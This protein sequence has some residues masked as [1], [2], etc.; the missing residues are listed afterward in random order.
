MRTGIDR[1]SGR[2]GWA[3]ACGLVLLST[4][5]GAAAA[6]K[7]LDP[8]TRFFTP[9]ADQAGLAQAISLALQGREREA[10]Q[11]AAMEL[12]P[13]GVW[14]NGGTTAAVAKQVDQTLLAARLTG[15]VPLLVLYNIPGRD[16]GGYSA[17]GA[18]TTADYQAWIDTIAAHIGHAQV[19]VALEPDALAN[20]PSDCGYDSDGSLT[21]ARYAQLGYALA[22][23]ESLPHAS[24]YLDAGHSAWHAVGDMAVRLVQAQT[25]SATLPV[26]ATAQG[27]FLNASNYQPTPQEIEYGTWISKCIYFA[28]NP[29]MGGWNLGHY[30]YCASQYYPASPSDFCTWSQSD[31]WYTQ[32]VDDAPNPPS[33]AGA[34]THFIIDSSRNGT[35][36]NNMSAYAAA[37]YDQSPATIGTLASGNWCNPP[38][39]GAGLRPTANVSDPA[40]DARLASATT[41]ACNPAVGPVETNPADTA[42]V[43][44]LLWIKVPGESD[45]TCDAQGGARAW[46]YTV[47]TQ[48]GWPTTAAA[49][50][51]FDPLW[52]L[53][54]PAAGLWFPQQALQLAQLASPPLL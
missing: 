46:D 38:G 6:T 9:P 44:A 7:S 31:A 20:L 33:G 13:R 39:A 22:A 47:Y 51:V 21:V 24:V 48:P 34:L 2:A 52:G 8:R 26:T 15:T 40:L 11:L 12:A 50:A 19:V 41:S 49:Q 45:G 28:N 3:L 1:K 14:L 5:A 25:V 10:L 36:A 29:G 17:G 23:L 27:F 53:D 54:D 4:A 16:C 42:L 32:N 43:D 37:P 35:G 18:E 30:D